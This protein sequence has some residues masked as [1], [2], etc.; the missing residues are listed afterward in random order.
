VTTANEQ[1]R[2]AVIQGASRG[3]GL[4]LVRALLADPHNDRIVASC[5]DPAAASALRDLQRANPRRLDIVALDVTREDSVRAAAA[6]TAERVDTVSLL[7]NC[8]GLLHGD[9][10]EPERRLAD[11]DPEHL[12]RLFAVN[13]FGPLLVAKHFA[14]LFPRQQR[15]VLANVSARVGSIGDNAL[16]GWYGYRGSK[17]AQN[18]FTRNLAIELKR[19]HRGIICVALH[20]GTVDTDLSQPF[21]RGVPAHKLFPAARA[22][23]QLLA[24]I[25]GLGPSANGG[26][27]AWDGSEIEW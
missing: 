22:A 16:G 26:F 25:D 7:I 9:H 18:M 15:A 5:R 21:Q 10:F 1:N 23:A 13:A 11:V 4:A 24:V 14:A 19:R 17:A 3:I 6:R 2:A 8:A 27:Y 12:Q 20:P